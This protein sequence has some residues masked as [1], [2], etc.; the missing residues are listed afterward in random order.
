MVSN[1]EWFNQ[2]YFKGD[3]KRYF[4]RGTIISDM[5]SIKPKVKAFISKPYKTQ[6]LATKSAY[7]RVYQKDGNTKRTRNVLTD[8]QVLPL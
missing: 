6:Y 3:G 5:S 1:K 2:P 8:F 4:V 7:R